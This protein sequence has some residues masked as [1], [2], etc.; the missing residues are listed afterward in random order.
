MKKRWV[1]RIGRGQKGRAMRELGMRLKHGQIYVFI[2][3]YIDNYVR[4]KDATVFR[5]KRAAIRD[6]AYDFEEVVA[7]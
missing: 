3:E 7:L 5:T 1:I 4:R 2:S 6:A